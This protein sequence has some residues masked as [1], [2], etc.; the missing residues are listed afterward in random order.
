MRFYFFLRGFTNLVLYIEISDDAVDRLLKVLSG[1]KKKA[2]MRATGGQH[3][4][5]IIETSGYGR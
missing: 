2:D 1:L 3:G 4:N 5:G